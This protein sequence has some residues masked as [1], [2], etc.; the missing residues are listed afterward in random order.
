MEDIEGK[1][2]KKMP[3]E[4][5]QAVR[6]AKAQMTQATIKAPD[7]TECARCQIKDPRASKV[8]AI[9]RNREKLD[10]IISPGSRA[11]RRTEPNH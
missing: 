11:I 4:L 10:A 1:E 5:R 6:M 3:R 8:N 2:I 9:F 7:E